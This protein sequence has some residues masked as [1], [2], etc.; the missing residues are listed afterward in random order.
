MSFCVCV[1]GSGGGGSCMTM[2]FV[3][4]HA[5]SIF[6]SLTQD[7]H[8][9]LRFA[10]VCPIWL[11]IS[12]PAGNMRITTAWGPDETD[13]GVNELLADRLRSSMHLN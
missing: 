3:S 11:F 13:L 2:W 4:L 6:A 8:T 5:L 12:S 9:I 7:L 1:Y 10:N